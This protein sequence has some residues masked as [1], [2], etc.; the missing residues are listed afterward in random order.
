MKKIREITQ[1]YAT[2][3]NFITIM[4]LVVLLQPIIDIDYLLYPYLDPIGLPLPST[5]IYFI[6]FPIVIGLAFLIK[7]Q[8]KKKVLIFI[9]II[10][11]LN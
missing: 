6:G 5:I 11:T 10:N 8:N 9:N 3:E 1:K 7:E 2:N 4:V